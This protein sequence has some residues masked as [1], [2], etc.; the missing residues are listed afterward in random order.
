MIRQ[1][2]L[3]HNVINPDAVDTYVNQVGKGH[4]P[5]AKAWFMK[6]LRV[7]IMNDATLLHKVDPRELSADAPQYVKDAI[8]RGE[9][10]YTFGEGVSD[11]FIDLTNRIQ[12]VQDF[13]RSLEEFAVKNPT[14]EIQK[15]QV[16]HA[17]R[18][19]SKLSKMNLEQVEAASY[20]WGKMA[21]AGVGG[22]EGKEG[23][24][25]I[26]QWEN[27]M[28][29]VR[30]EDKNVMMKDGKD[31]Q[32]CLQYGTYW[33]RV[34]S[35]EQWVVSIRKPNDEAVVGMRWN[36][37]GGRP[38][39]ISECKGKNNKPAGPIYVQYIVDLFR[40]FGVT[41]MISDLSSAGIFYN[42]DTNQYGTFRDIS[43]HVTSGDI[44]YWFTDSKIEFVYKKKIGYSKVSKRELY[45]P[46]VGNFSTSEIITIFRN[47]P[48]PLI[49]AQAA[50]VNLLGKGVFLSDKGVGSAADVG[51]HIGSLHGIDAYTVLKDNSGH[52][53]FM[54]NGESYIAGVM[55]GSIKTFPSMMSEKLQ[56][57]DIMS[58]INM[59]ES[60]TN[61]K[62]GSV[63]RQSIAYPNGYVLTPTG[64]QPIREVGEVFQ[65]I[66]GAAGALDLW[67]YKN[68]VFMY[69]IDGGEYFTF[70]I[71]SKAKSNDL[72]AISTGPSRVAG[73]AANA[74]LRK[75]DIADIDGMTPRECGAFSM[76]DK[77]KGKVVAD[78]LEFI[79]TIV[80][81]AEQDGVE[82][83][84][85]NIKFSLAAVMTSINYLNDVKTA[86][87]H[88]G[89][90]DVS[91][92]DAT[93]LFNALNPLKLKTPYH[94]DVGSKKS[95]HDLVTRK[96]HIILPT[97]LSE[98][99]SLWIKHP[100]L[101]ERYIAIYADITKKIIALIEKSTDEN[102]SFNHSSLDVEYNSVLKDTLRELWYAVRQNN[103]TVEQRITLAAN[104]PPPEA[105]ASSRFAA[106]NMLRQHR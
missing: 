71:D 54:Q 72:N 53:V 57:K 26:H 64:Y 5:E 35:G 95:I 76:K 69:T 48:S 86:A 32:N 77:G 98:M 13:F 19:L 11:G 49:V 102:I 88:N 9:D 70:S 39:T 79:D 50:I 81:R 82:P 16:V 3:E 83:G 30:Y 1:Y 27:G 80:G 29:A 7:H 75:F 104:N 63:M 37:S 23:V 4:S 33:D 12:H 67:S 47:I 91:L 38:T 89:L 87:L 61:V 8:A 59:C 84:L 101:N 22:V 34:V 97:P 41:G 2:L 31:L 73:A 60:N 36:L 74:I 43:T 25:I 52:I 85:H 99:E 46:D 100:K 17:Q 24:V 6:K 93:R 105:D 40:A 58:L 94:L 65:K 15:Q 20:E 55:N 42:N 68:K 78:P 92:K 56:A 103:N 28:Y 90:Y 45:D 62:L 14:N 51:E 66:N 106:L 96:A 44:D 10:V 18:W 21:S